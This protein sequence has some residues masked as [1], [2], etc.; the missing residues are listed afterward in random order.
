MLTAEL[1]SVRG[2]ELVASY[3][4]TDRCTL[5]E[6][7]LSVVLQIACA[8]VGWTTAQAAT[9]GSDRLQRVRLACPPTAS[10]A[11]QHRISTLTP[12]PVHVLSPPGRLQDASSGIIT[13]VTA[14]RVLLLDWRIWRNAPIPVQ[15]ALVTSLLGLTASTNPHAQLNLAQMRKAGKASVRVPSRRVTGH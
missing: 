11:T 4:S 7:I 14:F 13:N 3:L 1:M 6:D 2:L 8:F 9:S 10:A 15:T 5:D 12:A